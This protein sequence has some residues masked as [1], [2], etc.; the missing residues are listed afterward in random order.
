MLMI[1]GSALIRVLNCGELAIASFGFVCTRD[2]LYVR[3][4]VMAAL[5]PTSEQ[6]SPKYTAIQSM[7]DRLV[8][9]TKDRLR[10]LIERLFEKKALNRQQR[11]KVVR[12]LGLGSLQAEYAP[13]ILFGDILTNVDIDNACFDRTVL[14]LQELGFDNLAHDLRG[15]VQRPFD[16]LSTRPH[17]RHNGAACDGSASLTGKLLPKQ[18]NEDGD[19]G[20]AGVQSANST[21]LLDDFD[22][23]ADSDMEQPK[24]VVN[25]STLIPHNQPTNDP[26]SDTEISSILVEPTLPNPTPVT[27]DS[28]A[29]MESS[30]QA[31]PQLQELPEEDNVQEQA[32]IQVRDQP[33][34]TNMLLVPP[35][36]QFVSIADE[37][38]A[39][40]ETL[41]AQLSHRMNNMRLEL[42][43]KERELQ[44]MRQVS[45]VP[46]LRQVVKKLNEQ[47]KKMEQEVKSQKLNNEKIA[48]EKDAEI[49]KWKKEC[50][51]MQQDINELRMKINE[52]EAEKHLLAT[53]YMSQMQALRKEHARILQEYETKVGILDKQL[54][55]A[56]RKK[57]ITELKL[58]ETDAKVHQAENEKLRIEI[59]FWRTMSEKHKELSDMKDE[60]Y[61]L[62]LEIERLHRDNHDLQILVH[63]KDKEIAEHKLSD[64]QRQS[65][66]LQEENTEL[67]RQVSE[68]EDQLSGIA[69][70]AQTM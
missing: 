26:P 66:Q 57:E 1:C 43:Q 31:Q 59:M 23:E 46:R 64:E 38:D 70:R 13:V 11:D 25:Q 2:C 5:V 41:V 3:T 36:S 47:V 21:R 17:H 37:I 30:F 61:R 34:S 22:N 44:E 63:K 53:K 20:I 33:S 4:Y 6:P 18:L 68:Y 49:E 58:K 48:S 19:S 42:Q 7:F 27:S 16:A 24:L 52:Q 55:E 12:M 29:S 65:K 28:S 50:E 67:K 69:K 14:A 40:S 45:D 10:E 35:G 51:Q 32:P 60:K 54:Q 9:K 8:D 15:S 39:T 62:E 56:I